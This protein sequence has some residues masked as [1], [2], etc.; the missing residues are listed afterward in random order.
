MNKSQFLK[1]LTDIYWQSSDATIN[2]PGRMKAVVL[3]ISELFKTWAPSKGQAPICHMA[4]T[5]AAEML[6]RW[7]QE[8]DETA[9]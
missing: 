1:Q 3:Q 6:A 7:A 5:E 9:D 4:I 8:A 2:D